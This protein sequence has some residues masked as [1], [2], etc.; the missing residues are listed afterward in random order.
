[1]RRQ[2]DHPMNEYATGAGQCRPEWAK[3]SPGAV[4][5]PD[6][7]RA[8]ALPATN[9]SIPHVSTC[10]GRATRLIWRMV[11]PADDKIAIDG[12]AMAK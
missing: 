1:M 10:P 4:S 3:A 11:C 6:K 2:I 12:E 9:R 5:Q 7:A 8:A